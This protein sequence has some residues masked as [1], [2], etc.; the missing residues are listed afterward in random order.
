MIKMKNSILF[1]GLFAI[2][3][4]F[5]CKKEQLNKQPTNPILLEP[6]E[7]SVTGINSVTFKWQSTDEENDEILYRLYISSDSINW[8]RIAYQHEEIFILKSD[9]EKGLKYFWKVEADNDFSVSTPQ[10]EEGQ[11][12]SQVSYFYTTPKGVSDCNVSSGHEYI[13][14]NWYDTEDLDFVEITFEPNVNGITQPLIVDEGIEKVELNGFEDGTLYN[15]YFKVHNK[16]GHISEQDTIKA[17][18]LNPGQ[19]HDAD[20]NIYNLTTIGTQT[21]LRENLK[22]TKWQDGT[23]MTNNYK[24]GSRSDTYGF[25]YHPEFTF[26]ESAENKNPCPCGFH[27]PSDDEWKELERF[28]GMPEDEIEDYCGYSYTDRGEGL[29]IGNVLKSTTGWMDFNGA[30]GNGIDFYQFNLLP[31]GYITLDEEEVEFGEI[32][33]LISSKDLGGHTFIYRGFFNHS[34]GIKS[35]QTGSF[36]SIR[37]IID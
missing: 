30:N 32:S 16:L 10:Q 25:Y 33:I 28:L 34:S 13:N 27:V 7:G 11:S 21:W 5:S 4:L 3:M 2:L 1:I 9:L 12:V 31:A 23:P 20:F 15:F 37:C 8:E 22:T 26:G 14:I 24:I 6:A 36:N 35:C 29:N 17:L 18:P 19:V